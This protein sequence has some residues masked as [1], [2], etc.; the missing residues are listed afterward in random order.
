MSLGDNMTTHVLYHANCHDGMMSAVAALD[1]LKHE[2]AETVY[3]A[4]KYG[5]DIP[6]IETQDTV[7]CVDFSLPL[8]TITDLVNNNI[9]VRVIDHHQTAHEE[10]GDFQHSHFLLYYD[11]FKSGCV[12]TWEYFHNVLTGYDFSHSLNQPVPQLLLHVQDRDLWL[13]KMIDTKRIM[14]GLSAQTM[15]LDNYYTWLCDPNAIETL[16]EQ[17]RHLL[18]YRDNLIRTMAEQLNWIT[19]AGNHIPIVNASVLFSEVANKLVE[20]YTDIPFAAYYYGRA[21]KIQVGLRGRD[22]DGFDVSEVAKLYGGGGHKKASGFAI[23]FHELS[24]LLD[25]KL[26]YFYET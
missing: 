15:S 23:P 22:S 18:F 24:S 25:S 14:A 20:D 12:L 2:A 4:M 11:N 26:N 5:D 19:L 17:G 21:D 7:Y 9:L 16:N 1:I 8:K 13:Y 3:T 10:L 6:D